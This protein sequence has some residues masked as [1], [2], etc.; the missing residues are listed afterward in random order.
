MDIDPVFKI[1]PE[2]K[3]WGIRSGVYGDNFGS[4]LRLISRSEKRWFNHANDSFEVCGVAPS[5]WNHWRTLTTSFLRPNAVQNLRRT[6]TDLCWLSRS[7]HYRLRTRM[8]QWFHAWKWQPRQC[9]L[10]SVMVFVD[11]SQGVFFLRRCCFWSS[12]DPTTG[13]GPR[14]KTRH[15]QENLA[16]RQSWRKTTGTWS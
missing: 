4:H 10:N 6:W 2:I 8:V 3:T 5:C 16:Q 11:I 9:T 12:H 13:K 15:Y 1:F 7:A 14:M